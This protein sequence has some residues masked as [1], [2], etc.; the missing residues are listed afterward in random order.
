MKATAFL[1]AAALAATTSAQAKL[2]TVTWSGAPYGNSASATG[3]FD[4]SPDTPTDP[5]GFGPPVPAGDYQIISL[6]ITGASEGNGSFVQSDFD[7]FYFSFYSKL[8]F[9]RELIGQVMENG[10]AYGPSDDGVG[11]PSG[12]FNLFGKSGT[13]APF[14]NNFFDLGTDHGDGD[15]LAVTSIAPVAPGVPEPATWAMLI[16]GFDLLGSTLRRRRRS[17]PRPYFDRSFTSTR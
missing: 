2:F 10:I 8:D 7:S 3:L 13:D 14:G 9:N 17:A 5:T 4:L 12:D 15:D 6:A 11:G 1:F 16:G